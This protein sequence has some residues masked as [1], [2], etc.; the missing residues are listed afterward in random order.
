MLNQCWCNVGSASLIVGQQWFNVLQV[1]DTKNKY[2]VLLLYILYV[3]DKMLYLSFV[4]K[5]YVIDWI[6]LICL[7][8]AINNDVIQNVQYYYSTTYCYLEVIS[9]MYLVH[10]EHSSY[11][12]IMVE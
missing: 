10:L 2:S 11:Y 8:M 9:V 12:N 1:Y 3:I 6:L 5:A 7:N 4:E